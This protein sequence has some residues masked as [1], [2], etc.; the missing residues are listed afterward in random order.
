MEGGKVTNGERPFFS[1]LTS[2]NHK[3]YFG[4]TK[5]EIFFREN[6]FHTE[7]KVRKY[8]FAPSEKFSCY[9]PGYHMCA[10]WYHLYAGSLS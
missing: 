1:L 3:N 9:A 10:T 8:D 6:A 5:M 7:K 2:R 4:S